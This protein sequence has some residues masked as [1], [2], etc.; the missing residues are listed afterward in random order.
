MLSDFIS[1]L[2]I[3][4]MFNLEV[5]IRVLLFSLVA[6]LASISVHHRIVILSGVSI[7]SIMR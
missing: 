7:H 6:F 2:R 4:L 3:G 5:C 1:L